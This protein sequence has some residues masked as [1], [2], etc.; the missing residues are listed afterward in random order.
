MNHPD[1]V[2]IYNVGT[3]N[4]INYIATEYVE[5][6]TV[7]EMIGSGLKLDDILSLIIQSCEAL[8]AAH[9][10]GIIHRDIKPENIMA[11]PDGYIKI[12]D[13][14]LAKL[15]DVSPQTMS[16][17]AK[18]AK[19]VIIGTPA[20]MSPEQVAD[21]KVDHRT[22]LWSIGVVLYELLT[23]VNPF[24]KENR[25][26]TFQAILSQDPPPASSKLEPTE[27]GGYITGWDWSPDGKKLGGVIA[28]GRRRAIGYYSFETKRYEKLVGGINLIP[29]WLPD[30]RRLI[31]GANDKIIL[32]DSETKKTREIF[33]IPHM[34][35]RAPFISRDSSLLYYTAFTAE[36]DI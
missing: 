28:E 8:S 33:S 24:K 5:G 21:E 27:S 7:R 15:S 25:Q 10:A 20:Y 3:F 18:T 17:F 4:G 31:Y 11:R 26:A 13:F 22:D 16:N 2:T 30:S 12:L 9:S 23:G 29:S 6:K 1:I 36:S 14:G 32:V 35:L 19:G 34:Q